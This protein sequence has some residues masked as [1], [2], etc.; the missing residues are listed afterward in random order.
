M[1]AVSEFGAIFHVNQEI[2]NDVT[3]GL[4]LFENGDVLFAKIT[5][6][7]ENGKG[8]YVENLSTRYAFGSTE[9]HVLRPGY[10][11]FV[12]LKNLHK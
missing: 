2:F 3:K 7:M 11:Y 12:T 8:A 6:C 9:F 1:E 5:P 4:T 10:F